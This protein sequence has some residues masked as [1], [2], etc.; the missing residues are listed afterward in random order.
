MS[1]GTITTRAG[2]GPVIGVRVVA[3]DADDDRAA[4]HAPRRPPA[5]TPAAG[6]AAAL[7]AGRAAEAQEAGVL[8]ADFVRR[9]AGR[10]LTPGPLR[11]TSYDGHST[12]RTTLHGWYLKKNRSVAVGADGRYYVLTVPSSLRARFSGA[13]VPPSTPRLVVGAGGGD[14]ETIPLALL[15]ERRL[16]AGAVWP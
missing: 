16:E 5:P 11:A 4:S 12:Y 15:L 1:H 2:P 7:E 10:G 3:M 8:L 13:D 9:A 14:G 6:H